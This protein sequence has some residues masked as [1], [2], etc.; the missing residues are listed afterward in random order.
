MSNLKKRGRKPKN[1]IIV[2]ENPEFDNTNT[3]DVIIKINNIKYDDNDIN[4]TDN[5]GN[6]DNIGNA[7]NMDNTCN[8]CKNCEKIGAINNEFLPLLIHFKL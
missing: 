2:N 8:I 3:N 7:D 5:M 1:K 6:I 4:N